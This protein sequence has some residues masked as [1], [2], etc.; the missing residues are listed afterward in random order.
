[1]KNDYNKLVIWYDSSLNKGN[2]KAAKII[3]T[4]CKKYPKYITRIEQNIW[5]VQPKAQFTISV[6]FSST[7]ILDKYW[8]ELKLGYDKLE[9]IATRNFA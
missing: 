9:V 1:M 5:F 8:D 2:T 7:I 3:S 4:L 6:V